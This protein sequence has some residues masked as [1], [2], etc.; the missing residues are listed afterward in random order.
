[1]SNG[2]QVWDASALHAAAT[3]DRLDVL[4]DRHVQTGN[5]PARDLG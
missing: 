4:G 5:F 1:M 2:L 3:A